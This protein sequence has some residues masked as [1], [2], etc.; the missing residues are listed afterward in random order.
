MIW[1]DSENMNEAGQK[2]VWLTSM[3]IINQSM[4]HAMADNL[5]Q[6]DVLLMAI[7]GHW[8][9]LWNGIWKDLQQA[10]KSLSACLEAPF[11]NGKKIA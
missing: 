8:W 9:P 11:E 10:E 3:Q 1:I 7:D 4:W 2:S 5:Q 6:L